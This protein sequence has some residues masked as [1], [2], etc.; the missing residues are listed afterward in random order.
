MGYMKRSLEKVVMEA[1]NEYQVIIVTGPRQVGKTT[2]LQKL[3]EGT[4]RSYVT[5]DDLNERALAQSDPEMFFQ[6]HKPPILIDEVQYAPQLFTYI[7][8]LADRDQ[9]YGDF[10]LTGSQAF[11]LTKLAGESL[12]GRACILHMSTMSQGEIYGQ[13][14]NRPF[15][16]DLDELQASSASISSNRRSG[17]STCP[18]EASIRRCPRKWP[19]NMAT[20]STP[21]S[22]TSCSV[23]PTESCSM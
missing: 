15:T 22:L 20:T 13:D 7:K 8:I 3:M 12:A 18:T 21:A 4:N 16:L 19:A 9:R 2:M 1:C 17:W 10:W 23:S 14:E 11:K 5:L 6:M